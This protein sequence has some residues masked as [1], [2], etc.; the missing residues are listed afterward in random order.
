MKELVSL[1]LLFVLSFKLQS[2]LIVKPPV[3]YE[4]IPVTAPLYQQE[5]YEWLVSI[6]HSPFYVLSI[7]TYPIYSLGSTFSLNQSFFYT[8]KEVQNYRE[9]SEQ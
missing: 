2:Q 1:F 9:H 3:I 5:E 4:P 7:L 8:Q 6:L